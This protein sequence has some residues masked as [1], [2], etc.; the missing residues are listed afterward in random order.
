[1]LCRRAIALAAACCC[2]TAQAQT[3][4][5]AAAA[6]AERA[7]EPAASLPAVTVT[8]TPQPLATTEGTGSYTSGSTSTATGLALPPRQTPQ[9]VSVITRQRMDD[10]AMTQLTDVVAQTPGLALS[11]GGN[12]GSDS[13]PIYS[14]GFSV[15]NYMVDGVKLLESYTSIFQSQDMALYDRVE[16]VRGATGLMNGTGTPGATLNMVRKTPART[17]QA[18]AK[19]ELGSWRYRRADVDVSAP[20]NAQGSVRGRLVAAVQDAGSYIDRL[21]ED[22]AVLYGV[23]E[24]DIAAPTLLRAGVSHQRHDATGHARGGLPAFFSDGTRTTWQRS[25]SAASEWAYSKRHSTSAFATLEHLLENGWELKATAARTVT[26]SDELVGYASGG[27]PDRAS[28]AGVKV[29]ATHWKYRPRQDVLSLSA[30]GQFSLLGRTHDLAAGTTLSRSRRRGDPAYTNWSHAGWSGAVPSIFGWDGATPA[31]PPNP[32]IGTHS[33]DERDQSAFASVRLKPAEALSVILG[34]RLT[35]WRRSVDSHRYQSGQTTTTLTR[36]SG[37]LTP[38]A[39][40]VY[41]IHPHWSVY[42]SYTSIFQPQSY[43]TVDGSFI[44]PLMG[45]SHEVG[46]KGAFYDSRLNVAA[47]LYRT[48]EDNKAIAVP[49]TFAPDGSQAYRAVSGT[50]SRGVE[51]EVSG[52]LRPGW[53][54]AASFARNLSRDRE[55]ARL[56]TGVPQNTAKLF[57]TYRMGGAASGLVVGGGVRWQSEI[58]NLNMGPDKTRLVQPAYAVL[59]LMARYAISKQLTASVHLN[60]VFDKSYL[61]TAGNSYYG[62]PRSVRVMLQ[63]GF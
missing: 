59:D 31:A 45:R 48:T 23:V 3:G 18:S 7:S 63:G 57:T 39:G 47:A 11:Q 38:Y 5:A 37:R 54:L 61:T 19:L 50:Q 32:A 15:N 43:K 27:N 16:V 42:A 40:L 58:Y 55:G 46:I 51:L 52:Q 21:K 25:D 6:P 35:Y 53:E 56:N 13:S 8:A 41:D 26:D 17:F 12:V 4:P 28:G 22:R 34:S 1:M 24:A 30:T 33:S 49:D 14:R 20:L 10:Q 62:A 60:N 44:D 29:W 2:L 36:A 9:S